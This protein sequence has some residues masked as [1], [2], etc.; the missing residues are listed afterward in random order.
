MIALES[1]REFL[2]NNGNMVEYRST[3]KSLTVVDNSSGIFNLLKRIFQKIGKLFSI[4]KRDTVGI[5][6]KN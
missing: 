2:E 3:N 1:V 5:N 4:N 6:E